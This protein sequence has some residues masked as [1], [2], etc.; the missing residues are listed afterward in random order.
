M[1]TL[2][3]PRAGMQAHFDCIIR[4][5]NARAWLL[6]HGVSQDQIDDA[7]YNGDGSYRPLYNLM[8]EINPGVATRLFYT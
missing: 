3:A 8:A 4:A 7:M 2:E 1:T 6:T 5:I